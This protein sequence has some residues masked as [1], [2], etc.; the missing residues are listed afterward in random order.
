MYRA[1][2]VSGEE[3]FFLGIAKPSNSD[4]SSRVEI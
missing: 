4:G 3:N 1:L 2:L